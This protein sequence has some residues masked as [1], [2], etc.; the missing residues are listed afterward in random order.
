MT[1]IASSIKK[2]GR[3]PNRIKE[4][5][6]SSDTAVQPRCMMLEGNIAFVTTPLFNFASSSY[7]VNAEVNV[8]PIGKARCDN[9]LPIRG[10]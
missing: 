10:L 6:E 8:K 5:D 4:L 2:L 3:C 1:T 9:H 7:R